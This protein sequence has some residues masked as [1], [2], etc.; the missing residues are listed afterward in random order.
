MKVHS[1]PDGNEEAHADHNHSAKNGSCPSRTGGCSENSK[2]NRI[3]TM[4]G[5][6]D[7]PKFVR[8]K[9]KKNSEENSENSV[10]MQTPY[11]PAQGCC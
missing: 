4:K 6:A 5:P 10:A 2:V 9:S 3:E 1:E 8:W 7:L 11:D